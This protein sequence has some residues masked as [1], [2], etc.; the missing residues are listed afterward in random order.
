MI[1][2]VDSDRSWSVRGRFAL[3]RAIEW[4][5]TVAGSKV[6]SFRPAE[7]PGNRTETPGSAASPGPWREGRSL[8]LPPGW[9]FA[10]GFIDAHTHLL[11]VGM[12]SRKPDLSPARSVADAMERLRAWLEEHPGTHPVIAEGWDQ[13]NWPE[14]RPPLR[15]E[16]DDVAS[17]RPVALR[18]VCGHVAVL[19]T[20][21]LAALGTAWPNLD[22]STG[23]ALEALP[24]ALNRLWPPRAADRREAALRG[25]EAALRQG[26][27][28][29]HEMGHGQSFRAFG[30]LDAEGL[31]KLRISHYFNQEH[32]D[33]IS[34]LG[35]VAGGGGEWLRVAGIKF[36]LDGSIG[37]RSAA[38]RDPYP[39]DAVDLASV[40]AGQPGEDAREVRGQDPS[41]GVNEATASGGGTEALGGATGLLLW[42]DEDLERRLLEV[43][44]GGFRAALH[45]I[46]DGAIEQA[47]RV[48]EGMIRSGAVG[49]CWGPRLEHAEAL[50]P[51]L[52][53]RAE[54]AGFWFSMQPNFTA[55][56]QGSGG[57]YEDRLGPT[58]AR[59]LNPYRSAFRT[60]RLV[61]GSDCMP[62][63]PALGVWGVR[64]H[65]ADE[66][67]LAAEE[68]LEAYT[69]AARGCVDGPFARAVPPPE[70]RATEAD[71]FAEGDPADVVL[72]D[73]QDPPRVRG[74]AVA[75]CW[76]VW[77]PAVGPLPSELPVAAAPLSP[78]AFEPPTE[79]GG[80]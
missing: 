15:Q 7:R 79:T 68:A 19:S 9:C 8:R 61:L 74:V 60:G 67:R 37:G 54:A 12:A 39:R 65:P 43:A 42:T 51:D 22:E 55:R 5:L 72:L 16:I 27:T 52:L 24:L 45:A 29:I 31:L 80:A 44:E 71:A 21:A 57:L 63:G 78:A 50:A 49:R 34:E 48:V 4:E 77:D 2:P 32:F 1:E 28:W 47:V 46:G 40:R 76:E 69:V 38:F 64:H 6:V 23:L 73:D 11:G 70:R 41:A 53:G 33:A 59:E 17:G 30:D 18:R 25:Q 36:F 14:R 66:Q 62:L 3:N 75:G 13:S 35:W 26:V 58:R 56:W 10:P 20:S